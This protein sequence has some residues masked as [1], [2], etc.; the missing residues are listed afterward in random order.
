MYSPNPYSEYLSKREQKAFKKRGVPTGRKIEIIKTLSEE[1]G[2]GVGSIFDEFYNSQLRNAISHSDYIL[3]EN[4][5]RCRGGISGNKGFEISFEEL[6]RILLSAKAF[7][8][9]FFSIEQSARRVW[10]DQA[11]RAIP[12]DAHYKGMMEVLAD[13]EGLMCGFRV[14]WPNGTDSTYRRTEDGI[15]MVNCMLSA[16][17]KTVDLMVGMY[18]RNPGAFSPLV[19]KDGLPVYTNREGNVAPLE[20]PGDGSGDWRG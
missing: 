8:A 20:W 6:D 11:G 10:G 19:E 1:A 5:F 2:L 17:H 3:T 15:D 9:A 4:G 7:V 18:A 13:R 16:P 12:Y 14:H